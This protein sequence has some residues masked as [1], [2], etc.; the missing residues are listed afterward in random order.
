M[1]IKSD[2]RSPRTF[3]AQKMDMRT[4]C[5]CGSESSRAFGLRKFMGK[6]V[7]DFA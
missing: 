6:C 5:A 2:T 4:N 1:N 7:V 3:G